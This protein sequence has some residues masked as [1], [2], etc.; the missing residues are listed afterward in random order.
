MIPPGDITYPLVGARITGLRW[1]RVLVNSDPNDPAAFPC[2]CTASVDAGT[3]TLTFAGG[4]V[5]TVN[6]TGGP[7][8]KET[9]LT[10]V[11]A[12][13]E[14]DIDLPAMVGGAS[15]EVEPC[16]IF[17]LMTPVADALG[18]TGGDPVPITTDGDWSREGNTFTGVVPDNDE[19]ETPVISGLRLVNGLS[20]RSVVVRGSTSVAVTATGSYLTIRKGRRH[21]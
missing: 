18:V 12:T 8:V 9:V 15:A 4:G 13:A 11:T 21:E 1:L 10:W 17:W 16:C 5:C 19:E 7:G 3:L 14:V 6:L 2:A 20:S